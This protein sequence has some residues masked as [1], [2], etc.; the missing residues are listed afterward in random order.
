MGV[1]V[2]VL[3]VIADISDRRCY[4]VCLNDY[5][6]KILVPKHRHYA[7]KSSRTIHVP[8]SNAIQ[9]DRSEHVAIR[10]YAKR[11]KLFAAFQRFV[12]QNGVLENETSTQ[13]IVKL[14]RYFAARILSY[15]FWDDTEMWSV[16]YRYACAVREFLKSGD[17]TTL[18]LEPGLTPYEEKRIKEPHPHQDAL[19]VL[20]LW[21]L[22][23]LLPGNYEDVCREWFL[24]TAIG[25]LTS[26]SDS[27]RRDSLPDG[28]SKV[29]YKAAGSPLR[30]RSALARSSSK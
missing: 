2:P 15:D 21:E 11:A 1:G 3:L 8:V 26:Y 29:V 18:R 4:F 28:Y 6:D 25:Y 30:A 20:R 23:S 27:V 19:D 17:A 7:Q 12:Y 14:A 13:A 10:W 9:E 24:P 5:I 22:L 16:I